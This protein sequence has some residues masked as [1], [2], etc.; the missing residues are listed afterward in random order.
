MREPDADRADS[1]R[2][3]RSAA[4]AAGRAGQIPRIAGRARVHPGELGRHRL[5]DDHAARLTQRRDARAVAVS[6]KTGEQRRAVLRRHVDGL[7]DVLDADRHAVNRR[8]RLARSPAVRGAIRRRAR[9]VEVERDKSA[10][11]RLPGFDLGDAA[12]EEVARRICPAGEIRRRRK[13][14]LHVGF[15]RVGR[16][17]WLAF[18]AFSCVRTRRTRLYE[19]LCLSRTALRPDLVLRAA[20]S[21][22][23]RRTLQCML[24]VRCPL[25]RPSR[26]A[27]GAPQDEGERQLPYAAA[28]LAAG[29]ASPVARTI[30]FSI[31][32]TRK[33][34]R[35][36]RKSHGQT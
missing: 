11:P 19:E 23:S 28:A 9:G 2:R 30:A 35:P 25:E 8:K 18:V 12:L 33:K 1:H 13:K 15:C 3:G 34:I 27:F 17:H 6:P 31:S 20:R 7:D 5:A 29:C 4:R 14:W 36:P 24:P 21:A 22:A 26:R 16:V 10:D 32:T